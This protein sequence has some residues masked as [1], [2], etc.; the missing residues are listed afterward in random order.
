[1]MMLFGGRFDILFD[2]QLFLFLFG[3][4][5]GMQKCLVLGILGHLKVF[6]EVYLLKHFL[7]ANYKIL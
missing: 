4:N 7:L 6:D 2:F 1:M 3:F 5:Y